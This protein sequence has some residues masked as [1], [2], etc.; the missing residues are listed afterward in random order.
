M[1]TF[2]KIG[3]FSVVEDRDD[4][5]KVLIRARVREDL[6]A[7]TKQ[8][9]LLPG[10]SRRGRTIYHTPNADYPFR[11]YT[12]KKDWADWLHCHVLVELD[13]DNF[14]NTVPERMSVYHEVWDVL[15]RAFAYN[16][17]A[18]NPFARKAS[19]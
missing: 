3:F 7:L 2:T 5:T 4:Q 11:I 13:Y 9:K 1:W 17:F 18:H 19:R 16:P 14:K 8:L 15:R 6:E 12:R 10:N